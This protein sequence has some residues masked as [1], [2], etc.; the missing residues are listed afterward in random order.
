MVALFLTTT[1]SCSDVFSILNRVQKVIGL[2]I[3]QRTEIIQVL[4]QSVPTCPV[5]IEPNDR[6]KRN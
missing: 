1:I 2:S 5:K 3:Q 4:R 6:T